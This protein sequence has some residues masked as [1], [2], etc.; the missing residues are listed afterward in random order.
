MPTQAK[1]GVW[2]LSLAGWGP[3]WYGD[4][5]LSFMAPLFQGEKAY[6]PVGSNF[7]LYNNPDVNTA[8]DAAAKESDPAKSKDMWAAIDKKIMEDAAF[9]PITSNGQPTYH[10][11]HVHNTVFIPTYQQN[12]PANVW[13]SAK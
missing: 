10:A 11:S 7:G 13:L 4:A 5:A 1:A 12:D 3:D 2:D 9:Y 6:P 8:I